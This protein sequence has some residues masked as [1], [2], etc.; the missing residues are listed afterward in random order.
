MIILPLEGSRPCEG[1]GRVANRNRH[2]GS[3]DVHHLVRE[4]PGWP[5]EAGLRGKRIGPGKTICARVSHLMG[6][7]GLRDARRVLAGS[8]HKDDGDDRN[9]HRDWSHDSLFWGPYRVGPAE[10]NA[11]ALDITRLRD[12]A[13][14]VLCHL[15][16]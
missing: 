7:W 16:R 4:A 2:V 6:H 12:E 15:N 10:T 13:A 3:N 9:E 1:T 8:S 14:S 11:S 5:A